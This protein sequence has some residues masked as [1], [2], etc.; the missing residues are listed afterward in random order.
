MNFIFS[1]F[2]NMDAIQA[3]TWDGQN[4]PDPRVQL[5]ANLDML[6]KRKCTTYKKYLSSHGKEIPACSRFD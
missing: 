3:M 2:E 4:G 6:L 5:T 1:V